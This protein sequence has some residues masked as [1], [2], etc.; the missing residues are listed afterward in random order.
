MIPAR[1]H[2]LFAR[3]GFTGVAGA[4]T[5]LLEDGTC[6]GVRHPMCRVFFLLLVHPHAGRLLFPVLVW[7]TFQVF[8][9]FEERMLVRA[10]GRQSSACMERVRFRVCRGIW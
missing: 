5:L 4:V 10:R 1:I 3:P 8:L 7:T 6:A 2:A 9:P